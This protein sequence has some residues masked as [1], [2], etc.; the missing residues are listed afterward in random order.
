MTP[1]G[2]D[3][4]NATKQREGQ[5][6]FHPLFYRVKS[7]DPFFNIVA[8]FFRFDS[9]MI[10]I[11]NCQLPLKTVTLPNITTNYRKFFGSCRDFLGNRILYQFNACK[12]VLQDL[13]SDN[14][15]AVEQV[16]SHFHYTVAT[17]WRRIGRINWNGEFFGVTLHQFKIHT[18]FS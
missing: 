6:I 14:K 11:L 12:Y 8:G 13:F 17:S 3:I 7:P 9:M 4:T 15:N 18:C 2:K 16:V 10:I 5:T 1:I